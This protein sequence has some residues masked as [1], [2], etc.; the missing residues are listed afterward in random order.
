[1]GGEAPKSQPRPRLRRPLP[2]K[3]LQLGHVECAVASGD[4]ALQANAWHRTILTLPWG[5]DLSTLRDGRSN[6]LEHRGSTCNKLIP[7]VIFSIL[8]CGPCPEVV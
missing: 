6:S 1:M 7:L 5:P 8:S 3:G 2:K 4:L